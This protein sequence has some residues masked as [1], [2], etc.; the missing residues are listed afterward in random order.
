MCKSRIINILTEYNCYSLFP[1]ASS[2]YNLNTSNINNVLYFRIQQVDGGF[3]EKFGSLFR[4]QA[5]FAA[6]QEQIEKQRVIEE[7]AKL[8][9]SDL[10]NHEVNP[11]EPVNDNESFVDGE[12]ATSSDSEVEEQ[13]D[14]NDF[15]AAALNV[16]IIR[17]YFY[18]NSCV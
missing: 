11:E 17:F 14:K 12:G 15:I 7:A 6:T 18:I 5:E 10:A 2:L 16:I 13:K 3:F 4:E 1:V 9:P 8:S